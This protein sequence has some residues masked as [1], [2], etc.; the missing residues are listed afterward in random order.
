MLLQNLLITLTVG[1]ALTIYSERQRRLLWKFPT[2]RVSLLCFDILRSFFTKTGQPGLFCIYFQPFSNKQYNFLQQIYVK[3]CPNVH[4]VYGAG[5]RTHNILNMMS[6][7]I[8]TRP[9][10]P[11][12]SFSFISK[13]FDS[14]QE[15]RLVMSE[16]DAV[17]KEIEKL[18]DEVQESKRKMNLAESRSKL[19][20]EEV[21][22][23]L[24]QFWAWL[25][26]FCDSS[27]Q[28]KWTTAPFYLP[29]EG[30]A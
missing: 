4:P 23:V 12:R 7:P 9:G 20:D 18:Q 16:R 14:F 24:E 2:R 28:N 25:W 1:K 15:I 8:T 6:S 27:A 29:P 26:Q 10:L 21:K 5:I 30:S 17:L 3:K 22:P 19:N 13:Q 11:P